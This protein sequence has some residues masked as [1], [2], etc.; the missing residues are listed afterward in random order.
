M[1]TQTDLEYLFTLINRA[2]PVAQDSTPPSGPPAESADWRAPTEQAAV[3]F[4]PEA[5]V[6]SIGD[7]ARELA[8][9]TEVPEEFL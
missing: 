3:V 2:E 9:G 7:L 6:G 8:R 1:P 4:P 5:I